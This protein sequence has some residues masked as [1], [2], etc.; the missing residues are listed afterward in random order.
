MTGELEALAGRRLEPAALGQSVRAYAELRGVLGGLRARMEFPEFLRTTCDAFFLGPA[1]ALP[2][3]RG[4]RL[5]E[6]P[7]PAVRVL[8]AGSCLGRADADGLEGLAVPGA[9]IVA[10]LAPV[11][12]GLLGIR[13]LGGAASVRALAEA[14]LDSPEIGRRPNDAW[15][16]A[17]RE[18][19]VAAR[20]GA[21]V[22]RSLRFCDACSS[23]RLRVKAGMAPL[24]VTLIDDEGGAGEG[25]GG[26]GRSRLGALSEGVR[27]RR[28]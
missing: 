5:P 27:C 11:P 23:E 2:A 8:L 24:P 14:L 6:R 10:D 12:G 22:F 17:L 7:E 16:L 21:L 9:E 3:L 28:A 18:A 4:A 20:A 1:R 15:H 13:P 26:R 25:A 19:A